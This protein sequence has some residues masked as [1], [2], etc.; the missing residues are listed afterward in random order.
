[1]QDSE[2]TISVLKFGG[3]SFTSPSAYRTV[4]RYLASRALSGERLCVIVSAMSGTT[5]RLSELLC[6]IAPEAQPED[7]DAVLATGE[8]LASALVRAALVAEDVNAISLNAFQLGWRASDKFTSGQ[9]MSFPDS[10]MSAAFDR[11]QVVVVS[12]GQATTEDGRLVMLGRNSSD[13]TAIAAAVALKCNSVTMFSDVEGVFTADPYRL[14]NTRLITSLSYRRAITYS[15][16]GAKVLYSGCIELAQQHHIRI[17]CASLAVEGNV[18][19]GTEISEDGLGI[20]VCM[21]ENFLICRF[22]DTPKDYATPLHIGKAPHL[23][24]AVNRGG[25]FAARV[26]DSYHRMVAGGA[27]IN[28]DDLSP[29]L[30]FARD[31]SMEVHAVARDERVPY[32]QAIHE[33]LLAGCP[34]REPIS[35]LDK[36][37]GTHTN[38]FSSHA[39]A[40]AL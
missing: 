37:R 2:N 11:A 33:V 8:I 15:Q 30:A 5:G 38:V 10:C 29:I 6:A 39:E 16:F 22:A 7:F 23:M 13:L 21:P 31:G 17:Q 3:S 25:Y 1:M 9:L 24:S 27:L 36:Q 34:F 26:D 20:Q 35:R 14:A 40:A 12:G 32:A 18:Y 19:Y 4:A 28:C